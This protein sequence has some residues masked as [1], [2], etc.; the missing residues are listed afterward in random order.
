MFLDQKNLNH[1]L[2]IDSHFETFAVVLVK[3]ID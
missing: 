2:A 1:T 3:F